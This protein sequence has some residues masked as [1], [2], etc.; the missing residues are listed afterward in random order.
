MER[1]T[2]EEEQYLIDNYI[3]ESYCD[4]SKKIGKT[5]GAIRAKCFDLNLVKNSAWSDDELDFIKNNYQK[6]S[7]QEMA[8]YL[9][10]TANAVR[11]KASR[12]GC[13]KS[14]YNCNYDFFN[15]INTEE[16]AY[17]LGFIAADGWVTINK[18]SNA[19]VIGIELQ[20]ADIEHLRKFNKSINGNYKIDTF[21]KICKIST[22]P[23]IMHKMCRIRI[24]SINMV[25]DL[26]GLG[27]TDN[28]TYDFQLPKLENNLMRHFIRG[29][30]DGD[31]CIRTRTKRLSS[32]RTIEYPLCD[33]ASVNKN[34]LDQLRSFL[35]NTI[36]VCS[37][38]YQDHDNLYRL[39]IHKNDHTINFLNY[40]YQDSNIYLDRK[41]QKYLYIINNNTTHGSL[42]N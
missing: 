13:K 25:N 41:Y 33:F 15:S 20:S 31:G 39:C 36:R 16:K 3:T 24:F 28:K 5:E 26:V 17:W 37:Y 38:I 2:K 10:R 12:C 42:A 23:D 4:I 32:G 34:F 40:M 9:N 22:Y 21:D 7:I 11:L 14:P 35:Y 1:W 8:E 19:G 30:F 29:Y 27:I 18:E 6:M